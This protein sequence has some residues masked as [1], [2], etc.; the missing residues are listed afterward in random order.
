MD[1]DGTDRGELNQLASGKGDGDVAG[2]GQPDSIAALHANRGSTAHSYE[3]TVRRP[4]VAGGVEAWCANKDHRIVAVVLD[5]VD[6]GLA[7]VE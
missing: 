4:A 2:E 7:V 1:P 5:E 3:V 6:G